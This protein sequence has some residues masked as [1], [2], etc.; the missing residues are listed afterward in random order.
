MNRNP[1]SLLLF[2]ALF[3]TNA[4]SAQDGQF[5][6]G[7][8]DTLYPGIQFTRVEVTEPRKLVICVSRVDTQSERLTFHTTPRRDDWKVG[9]VE[10]DRQKTRDFLIES[11]QNDIPTV[12]AIN[13]DAFSP[14][15]A[16]YNKST[17]ADLLGLAVSDGNL[18]SKGSGPP[19]SIQT[20]KGD[21]KSQKTSPSFDTSAV[22][23]AI[24]GFGICLDEGEAVP[25]GKDLHPRTGIGLS[26]DAR[27]LFLIVV[28]GRQPSSFGVTTQ[29]LGNW[30]RHFGANRGINLD[31][32]GSTT[33]ACWDAQATPPRCRLLN[34]PVGNGARSEKL[35]PILF[36]STERANGNN[37]GVALK[38]VAPA[39]DQ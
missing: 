32:G 29:E 26:K 7:Q 28:D 2:I 18:V 6:W 33:M 12:L 11:R 5:D 13:A 4:S 25:S 9:E 10:T 15:P 8:S 21:W 30:L 17:P 27:Y 38:P 34:R 24:S 3:G 22:Q 1:A 37:F 16:P 20:R 36:L 39:V 23:L 19:S 35:A 14:W 31:G